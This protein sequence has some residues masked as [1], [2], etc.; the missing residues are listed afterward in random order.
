MTR[1]PSV[2]VWGGFFLLLFCGKALAARVLT[3]EAA[4]ARVA[5]EGR[6]VRMADI[7]VRAAGAQAL[8]ER[9]LFLPQVSAGA[10]HT[11]YAYQP[12]SLASGSKLLTAEKAFFSYGI[13]VHQI[14]FDFGATKARYKSANLAADGAR[15]EVARARNKAVLSVISI[16]FDVL[17]S[18]REVS[19]SREQLASLARHARD[20][21]VLCREGVSTRSD[22]L[23]VK[24]RFNEARQKLVGTRNARRKALARL[25]QVLFLEDHADLSLE[26]PPPPA[27]PVFDLRKALEFAVLRRPDLRAMDKAVRAAEWREEFSRASERPSLFA[28]GAYTRAENRYQARDDNWQGQLGIRFSVFN[29]G[30]T[31]AQNER[32]RQEKERARQE[33]DKLEDQVRYEVESAMLDMDDA[34]ERATLARSSAAQA[35]ENARVMHVRY[36]EGTGTSSDL[37]EALALRSAAETELWRGT[38]EYKR[39]WARFFDAVGMDLAREYVRREEWYEISE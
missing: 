31:R 9:S 20:V 18:E 38:Y 28:D 3:L 21:F 16:Y 11:S 7:A 12:A 34:R 35:R 32:A 10:S 33:H 13:N 6:D 15:D 39:A 36:R 14:L 22:F 24:V 30:L 2:V 23:T 17:E 19:V 8:A 37:L 5:G 1:C 26:D 25:R 27:C 4:V 29:G